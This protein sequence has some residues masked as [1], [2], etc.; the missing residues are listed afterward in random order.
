MSLKRE[1][2]N[3]NQNQQVANLI[4]NAIKGADIPEEEYS[5]IKITAIEKEGILTTTVA[6]SESIM[7]AM[8][9]QKMA[10]IEKMESILNGTVFIIRDRIVQ[11]AIGKGG[12]T[13]I[14]SPITH[15]AYQE[16]VVNDLVAPSHIVDRRTVVREDGSKL[17][18]MIIDA[19]H[20]AEASNRFE[21]MRVVFEEM[22]GKKALFLAN[23]Y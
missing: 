13:V 10:L 21:P 8:K 12:K 5:A 11:E 1:D 23:Y 7:T 18:K 20:K 6:V 9:K 16:K 17:E 4:K 14:Q 2:S 15:T 3:S 19:K 22:F